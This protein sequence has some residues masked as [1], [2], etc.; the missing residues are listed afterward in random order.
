MWKFHL[1]FCFLFTSCSYAACNL[2]NNHDPLAIILTKSKSCPR[3]IFA[4]H[5]L[6]KQ[7][8]FSIQTTMVAN[9]GFHNPAQGS[10]SLFEM[11]SGNH[12]KPGEFFIGHFTTL[13]D[14]GNLTLDQEAR[15]GALMIETFAFDPVK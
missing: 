13:N 2:P 8:H 12:I 6:L 9:R 3:D 7:N 1:L 11:I 5:K 4:L 15:A 10:F 14:A